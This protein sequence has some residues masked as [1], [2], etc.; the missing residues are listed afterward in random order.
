MLKGAG[1]LAVPERVPVPVFCTVKDRSEVDCTATDPKSRVEGVTVIA[2]TA[3]IEMVKAFER[4]L[5]CPPSLAL[6]AAT[7]AHAPAAVA[8]NPARL[9]VAV[10]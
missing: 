8:G 7:T 2:G 10:S 9:S 1:T 6:C 5:L 4:E 3:G